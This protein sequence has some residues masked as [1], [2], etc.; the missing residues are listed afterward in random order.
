MR[1]QFQNWVKAMN[2][3]FTKKK[4]IKTYLKLLALLIMK[5]TD[6]LKCDYISPINLSMT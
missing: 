3:R 2:S 4:N 1:V 5:E 6:I